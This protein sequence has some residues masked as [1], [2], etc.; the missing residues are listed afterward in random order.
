[1]RKVF[2]VFCIVLGI[3]CLLAA[4]GL[5]AYNRM[6]E[7]NALNVSRNILQDVRENMAESKSEEGSAELVASDETAELTREMLTTQVEGYDCIG[8]LSIP[9]LELP[10]RKEVNSS[11]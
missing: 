2:G 4:V 3:C 10:R 1:M 9:V 5:I 7:E 8:V 6:E 11:G